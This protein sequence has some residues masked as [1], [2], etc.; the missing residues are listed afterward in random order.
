MATT[1]TVNLSAALQTQL[2]VGGVYLTILVFDSSS[3]SP[4]SM[5]I[6][7]GDGSQDGPIPASINV[8]LTAGS[9]T[10]DGGKIY[11]IIQSTDDVTPLRFNSQSE[12]NWQSAADNSYR[13][14]SVE[15]SL[16][17]APGDAA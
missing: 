12:I 17:N 13:Y 10:L 11:F 1:M 7:A 15:I 14:D 4:I 16:L 3:D 9:G 5:E 8:P 6:Y 2:S